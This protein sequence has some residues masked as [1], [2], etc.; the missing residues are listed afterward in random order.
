MTKSRKIGHWR[1]LLCNAV[2]S[3]PTA[4][5]DWESHYRK[6]HYERPKP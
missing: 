2:G 3:G 5:I 1:C 6:Y 4:Y